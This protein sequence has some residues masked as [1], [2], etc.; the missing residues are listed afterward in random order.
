VGWL[1]LDWKGGSISE[2]NGLLKSQGYSLRQ[3]IG[4]RQKW[5]E[6]GLLRQTADLLFWADGEGEKVVQNGRDRLAHV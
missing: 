1:R 2:F 6:Q 5:L 4:I 3:A